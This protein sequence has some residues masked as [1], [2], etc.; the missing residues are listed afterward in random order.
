MGMGL[1]R[2]G[3]RS[4]SIYLMLL[5]TLAAPA[6]AAKRQSGSGIGRG[7]RSISYDNRNQSFL[8]SLQT[9]VAT[10]SD[11]FTEVLN[12]DT[13]VALRQRYE[14][15]NRGYEQRHNAHVTDTQEERKY[16]ENLNKLSKEMY[17]NLRAYNGQRYNDQVH[18]GA[19][20]GKVIS[21]VMITGTAVATYFGNPVNFTVGETRVDA[22]THMPDREGDLHLASPVCDTTF[23]YRGNEPTVADAQFF[24]RPVEE[25]KER[26]RVNL[27]KPLPIF[28]LSSSVSYG[29]TTTR[30]ITAL[31]R[32]ITSNV[33]AI[34]D[35]V[36]PTSASVASLRPA[37]QRLRLEYGITF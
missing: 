36:R 17:S 9:R 8:M 11:I 7:S 32:P 4:T 13:A 28:N 3:A 33:T 10:R 24:A 27:V 6:Q 14:D 20:E 22:R 21:P 35:S 15:L 25:Q 34:V 31:S 23:E 19:R 29:S 12:R 2:A 37:E 18:R 1:I 16:H 26:F 5:A 30:V